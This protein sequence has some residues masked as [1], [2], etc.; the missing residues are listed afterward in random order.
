MRSHVLVLP[1]VVCSSYAAASAAE[2][3]SAIAITHQHGCLHVGDDL[4]HTA[5]ELID[6]AISPNVAAVVV[7]SLGCETLNGKGL[8]DR[9]RAS[10]QR[11]EL[12]GIQHEGGTRRAIEAGR[13]L[14]DELCIEAEARRRTEISPR[15]LTVGIDEPS[16]PLSEPIA[17]AVRSRGVNVV[18]APEPRRGAEA[19]VALTGRCAQLLVSLPA[20]DEGPIGFAVSPVVAVA[21]GCELH[22]ALADDFDVVRRPGEDASALAERVADRV[23]AHADGETTASERRGARDVVLQRLAVT[24]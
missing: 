8:A 22:R 23:L 7:L 20:E 21:R 3:T 17:A 1:S 5:S 18:L 9:I 24:M 12:V 4:T 13:R 14:V 11:T 6:M 2:G 15:E 16:D 10:G 19:H